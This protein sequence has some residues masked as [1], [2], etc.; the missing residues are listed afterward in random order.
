MF[1]SKIRQLA[2][3]TS[4]LK[5]DSGT[6]SKIEELFVNRHVKSEEELL[7]SGHTNYN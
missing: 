4:T 1:V 5:I 2:E 7:A 3:S 6:L